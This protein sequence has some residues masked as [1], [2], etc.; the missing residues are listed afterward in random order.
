[1]CGV[2]LPRRGLNEIDGL[3]PWFG[4][5]PQHLRGKG[6]TDSHLSRSA[7]QGVAFAP[8]FT[9]KQRH[10]EPNILGDVG[11]IAEALS[12]PRALAIARLYNYRQAEIA[13]RN[14]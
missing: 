5:A 6:A 2:A 4:L 12:Q 7:L 14:S 13:T 10:L 1:M 3:G 11:L 9:K 8:Y